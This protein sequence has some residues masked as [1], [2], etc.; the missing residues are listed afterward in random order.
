MNTSI[1]RTPKEISKLASGAKDPL[2][3]ERLKLQIECEKLRIEHYKNFIAPWLQLAAVAGA[4]LGVFFGPTY[5]NR[6][7]T[8]KKELMQL[9]A[10]KS[11]S[12]AE[13]IQTW[14]TLFPDEQWLSEEPKPSIAK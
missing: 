7:K 13:V 14:N 12:K 2:E 10:K 9:L 8:D 1:P 6:A 3:V 5:F 11:T 4:A